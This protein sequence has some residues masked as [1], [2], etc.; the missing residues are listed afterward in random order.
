MYWYRKVLWACALEEDLAQLEDGD[1]SLVGSAGT[2]LS[3]GQKQRVALA[4]AVYARAP[5]VLLDDVFSALDR[6]TS[7]DIFSRLLGDDGLLRREHTAV[8]LATYA[9][10]AFCQPLRLAMP[11]LRFG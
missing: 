11:R 10:K 9:N 4:R 5:V 7:L 8:L 3:G 6:S 2:A 1:Q